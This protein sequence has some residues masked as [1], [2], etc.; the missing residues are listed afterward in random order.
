MQSLPAQPSK[1][2][3]NL[4]GRLPREVLAQERV[5]EALRVGTHVEDFVVRECRPT[6]SGHVADGVEAGLAIG[7]ADVGQHVHQVGHARQR[8]EVILHVLAGGEVAF[9]AAELVGDAAELLDLRAVSRPP[10][11]LLRTI[12]TPGWRWP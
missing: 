11:I 8:D 5:G 10:G 2:N 9:A 12:C 6:G 4:R 7:Q 1:A 3:L